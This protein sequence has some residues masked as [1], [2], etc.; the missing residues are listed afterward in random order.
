M[1][2]VQAPTLVIVSLLCCIAVKILLIDMA[3]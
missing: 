1:V 2:R 3:Q